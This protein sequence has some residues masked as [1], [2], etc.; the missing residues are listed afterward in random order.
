MNTHID[1]PDFDRALSES[2][3]GSFQ[4]AVQDYLQGELGRVRQQMKQ[5]LSPLEFEQAGKIEAAIEK[6]ADVIR[7]SSTIHNN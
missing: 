3:D 6:A 5:G 4:R 1:T 2:R 7:F